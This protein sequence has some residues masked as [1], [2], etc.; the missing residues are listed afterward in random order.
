[1]YK[2]ETHLHTREVSCCGNVPARESVILYREAGYTGMV[3]TDHY[4][5]LYF[6]KLGEISW[7][8]KIECL[9]KGYRAAREEGIKNNFTVLLGIELR[10][11]DMPHDF[12]VYGIDEEFLKDNPKL[13]ELGIEKFSALIKEKKKEILIY[14]A[15]P[16]RGNIAAIDKR[17]IDGIEVYNGHMEHDSQNNLA[18]KYAQE[19]N[20]LKISGT[21]FHET[22]HIAR[23]GVELTEQVFDMEQFVRALK[24]E[25]SVKLIYS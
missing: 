3:V 4:F 12:L 18:L 9:L 25:K 8:E 10:F 20:L 24:G 16:F 7:N 1:M 15:H 6:D 13:Y 2:Y 5:K 17:L 23:G 21:D 19:H 22:H 11:V 14:Q